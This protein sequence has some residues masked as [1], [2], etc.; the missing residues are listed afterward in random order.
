MEKKY[1]KIELR[2]G[3]SL[4][5]CVVQLIN[6]SVKNKTLASGDFNGTIL[7]SDTVSLDSAYS[8]ATGMTY[9]ERC[10]ADIVERIK[11]EQEEKE[12]QNRLPTRIAAW[13][14]RGSRLV[15]PEKFEYWMQVVPIR[16]NDLY[17]GMELDACLDIIEILNAGCSMS[18][19]KK[20]IEDQNHSGMSYSLVRAL[21]KEFAD[22]GEEFAKY[23]EL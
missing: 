8:E 2:W 10:E 18:S 21:V 9:F 1:E 16:A 5:E 11:R 17:H 15:K 22:R 14:D 6:Y 3:A 7:Y 12:R 19:A 4:G 13:T 20:K 23:V